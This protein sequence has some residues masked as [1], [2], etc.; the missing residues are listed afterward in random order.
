MRV[1]VLWT[2]ETD[3]FW[4]TVR[5]LVRNGHQAFVGTCGRDE[6]SPHAMND[7]GGEVEYARNLAAAELTAR[8]DSF[9]PDILVVA[10]W[11][12]PEFVTA[13][14]HFRGRACRVLVL[15]N[16]W[17]A[18]LKQRVGQIAFRTTLRDVYDCALV[19]GPRQVAFAE[20]M[21]LDRMKIALGGIPCNYED[22]DAPADSYGRYFLTAGRLAPEKGVDVLLDAYRRYRS[23]VTDPW[24]LV[25]CGTGPMPQQRLDGVEWAGFAAPKELAER[26]ANAGAFVLASVFEPWAVVLHEAAASGR[27]IIASSECG[28]V[29]TF[30]LDG[31]N[32]HVART[33]DPDH[34]ADCLEL[35]SRMPTGRLEEWG[36]RSKHLAARSTPDTWVDSVVNLH[37]RWQKGAAAP[38]GGL[39][40]GWSAR[41]RSGEFAP[42]AASRP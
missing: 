17:R 18:T 31:I 22:F 27:P 20:H 26:M 13:S 7:G 23:R 11:H 42:G 12:I 3:Y 21:G 4:S 25:I 10:G 34:L 15:D 5:A 40:R 2:L 39:R 38:T 16:Q 24:E 9:R 36:R 37:R 6:D 29:G 30:V 28:A 19:P 33:G 8:L 14:R 32:G 35:V 1:A 41:R